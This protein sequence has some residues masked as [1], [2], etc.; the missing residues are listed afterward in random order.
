[1]DSLVATFI[2]LDGYPG[3]WVAVYLEKIHAGLLW[4]VIEGRVRFNRTKATPY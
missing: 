3:G 4:N 2:G 1:M